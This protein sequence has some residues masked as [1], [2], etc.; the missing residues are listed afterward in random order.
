[1]RRTMLSR[2]VLYMLCGVSGALSRA[3]PDAGQVP[4]LKDSQQH[5]PKPQGLEV[6]VAFKRSGDDHEA[7]WHLPLRQPQR[8]SL[9]QGDSWRNARKEVNAI[10]IVAV[11][12]VQT[13][14][15]AGLEELAQVRCTVEP[16]FSEEEVRAA[17]VSGAE[18]G[19][20]PHFG[21]EDGMVRFDRSES[22]WFLAGRSIETVEC[23]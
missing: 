22:R 11:V 12:D 1:M 10:G 6:M 14:T 16:V 5:D 18:L 3:V 7:M 8:G 9:L 2:Y 19:V 4:L 23:W 15:S 20:W 17:A 13:G 21:V